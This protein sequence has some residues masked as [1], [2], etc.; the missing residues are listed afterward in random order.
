[1]LAE[2]YNDYINF[3]PQNEM[4]MYV[5]VN[6]QAVKKQPYDLDPSN[7]YRKHIIRGADWIKM[8][9]LDCRKYLHTMF[10]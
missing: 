8:T 6:G 7:L 9:W 4:V 10:Q 1:M 5:S 3:S 2:M